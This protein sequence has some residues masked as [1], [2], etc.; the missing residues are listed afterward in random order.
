MWPEQPSVSSVCL[1]ATT[2]T[3][4]SIVSVEHYSEF[5]LDVQIHQECMFFSLGRSLSLTVMELIAAENYWLSIVQKDSFPEELRL[6]RAKLPLP[7]ASRL[8]PLRP[9]LDESQSLLRVDGRLSQSQLCYSQMHPIILHGTHPV[10]KLIVR[11]EHLRLIHAGPTLLSSSL[12]RRFHIIGLRK[13]VRSVTSQCVTLKRHCVS[14]RNQLLGQLPAERVTPTSTF[15]KV[16]VDYAGLQIEYGH[17]RK[18]TVLKSYICLFVYLA[19]KAVHM[20]L[21]S[22]LI[23]EAFIAALRR[24]VARHGLPSLIW[25]DHGTN[26]VGANRESREFNIFLSNQIAQGAISEFCSCHNIEWKYIPERSPNLVDYGSQ[27]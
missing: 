15:Y 19:V 26:F 14:P 2:T 3:I 21:V 23:S 24:F 10:T 9:L 22:D 8:L 1:A 11:T 16:G 13:V 27:Q 4:Q 18:P 5:C 25:S 6:L 17:V 12:G 7:K 20:E